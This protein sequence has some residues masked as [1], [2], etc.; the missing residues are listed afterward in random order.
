MESRSPA[1]PSLGLVRE[2]LKSVVERATGA[3]AAEVVG[4]QVI[5]LTGGR[6]TDSSIYRLDVQVRLPKSQQAI[7]LPLVLKLVRLT[8]ER[9]SPEH[10]SY[11]L[12]E[13]EAYASGYLAALP[14]GLAAPRCFGVSWQEDVVWIWLEHIAGPP[15][16][17]WTAAELG[18]ICYELGRFNGAYLAGSVGGSA[19][20]YG[21]GE[22]LRRADRA[23]A[24][25]RNAMG[26]VRA[27][28]CKPGK[29]SCRR[30]MT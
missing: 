12:R 18:I 27:S 9:C 2:E 23:I 30:R 8:P 16:A 21:A 17:P 24:A 14:A 10:W 1:Q 4:W 13:A 19:K 22:R 5:Q 15:S 20:A 25:S 6:E 7:A 26:G 3:S 11:W 28:V 29:E